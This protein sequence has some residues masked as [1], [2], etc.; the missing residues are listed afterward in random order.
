M[1]EKVWYHSCQSRGKNCQNRLLKEERGCCIWYN[2]MLY[3]DEIEEHLGCTI[4]QIPESLD[5]PINEFDG[6]VVYG[7]KRKNG[8]LKF[9]G[10]VDILA[11]S[12]AELMQLEKQTQLNFLKLK[13]SKLIK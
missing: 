13:Y 4:S 7:E 6:R 9:K 1:P 2:E 5:V 3:L 11:P 8:G 12:V 10:H